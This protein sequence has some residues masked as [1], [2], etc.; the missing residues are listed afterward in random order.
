MPDTSEASTAPDLLRPLTVA[1]RRAIVELGG[2]AAAADVLFVER[3]EIS[4]TPGA[5][6]ALRFGQIRRANPDLVAAIRAEL[7]KARAE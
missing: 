4:P 2:A 7:E 1:G 3:W 5:A 6:A